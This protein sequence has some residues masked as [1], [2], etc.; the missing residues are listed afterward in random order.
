MSQEL[1]PSSGCCTT[2][3]DTPVT[4]NVP[5]PQGPAGTNGTNG[6]DGEDAYTTLSAKFTIPALG[7]TSTVGVVN[8]DCIPTS[9]TGQIWV[10][11]TG[12][13]YFQVISKSGSTLTLQNP[14]SGVLAV[15]NTAPTTQISAGTLIAVAGGT[16]AVG[17]AGTSGAPDSAR[18]LT[19]IPDSGLS[20]EVAL[21][22][23]SAGYMKTAGSSGS[24]ALSTTATIPVGDISGTLPIANGGT[25]VTTTP[26]NGA[27]PI[28]TGSGYTVTTLTA[29]SGITITNASGS[30][31]IAATSATLPTATFTCLV[32]GSSGSATC[33]VISAATT[34]NPFNATTY[35]SA[36]YTTI[37]TASGFTSSSGR[38]TVQSTG[39]YRISACLNLKAQGATASVTAYIRKNG[40]P[41][42][43]SFPVT[44]TSS[45]Y[46]PLSFEYF[47][48][49]TGSTDYYEIYIA[50]TQNLEVDQGSSFSVFRTS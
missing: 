13:G 3:S 2:C 23:Y 47:D 26:A 17:A 6:A 39:K 48:S 36:G 29:G 4:V 35:S 22:S 30:I 14:A 18:Y 9:L 28:G 27:I 31:T 44:V 25:G 40:S 24:G 16:G 8:P 15:P 34:S 42:Y 10:A 37:D 20:A 49:G 21:S 38:Y 33:P 11:I 41:V 19:L 32:S 1:L 45:G 50:P 12:A 43:T 5:G 7:A 46:H